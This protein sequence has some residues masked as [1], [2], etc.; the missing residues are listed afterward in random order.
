MCWRKNESDF[1]LKEKR[2][3]S[4]ILPRFPLLQTNFFKA[5]GSGGKYQDQA[6]MLSETV[7]IL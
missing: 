6:M 4:N 7:A 3:V 2:L 1:H 5:L